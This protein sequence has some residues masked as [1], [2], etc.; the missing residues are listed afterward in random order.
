MGS[1]RVGAGAA[2]LGADAGGDAQQGNLIEPDPI[3]RATRRGCR[4]ELRVEANRGPAL[5]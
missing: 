2:T 4:P 3:W 1:S 5:Y